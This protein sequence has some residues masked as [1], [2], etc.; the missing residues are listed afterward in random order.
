M[1]KINKNT[2]LGC[3]H[4][5]G[6]KKIDPKDGLEKFECKI[7]HF[8]NTIWFY[9]YNICGFYKENIFINLIKKVLLEDN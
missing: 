4:Y 6:H 5:T 2:C 3:I 9:S 7:P 1:S 8:D